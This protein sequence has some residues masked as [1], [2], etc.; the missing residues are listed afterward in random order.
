[1]MFRKGMT[2]YMENRFGSMHYNAIGPYLQKL[3]GC[4]VAKLAIDGGFTCPNRDGTKGVGGCIYCSADG[5]GHFASN[6]PDQ[7]KLLSGK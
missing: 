4:R 3:F 2:I 5:G 7:M 1:M 6:I